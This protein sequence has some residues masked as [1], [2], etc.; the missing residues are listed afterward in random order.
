MLYPQARQQGASHGNFIDNE[1][2]A[3]DE[4]RLLVSGDNTAIVEVCDGGA[5]YFDCSGASR[6]AS[7]HGVGAVP[8][9]SQGN[10]R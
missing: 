10:P 4:L 1:Q 8:A 7:A 6:R 9:F 2:K 5:F 3:P